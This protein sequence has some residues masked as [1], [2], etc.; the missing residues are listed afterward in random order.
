MCFYIE[1]RKYGVKIIIGDN[2]KKRGFTLVE[3]IAVIAVMGLLTVIIAPKIIDTFKQSNDDTMIIQEN[4]VKDSANLF[5]EDFCR[6]PI[7]SNHKDKCDEYEKT[8]SDGKAYFCLNSLQS[9]ISVVGFGTETYVDEVYYKTGIPCS[10]IVVFDKTG[11]SYTNGKVYLTCKNSGDTSYSYATENYSAYSNEISICGG[12]IGSA[13]PSNPVTPTN[14]TD[15]VDPV[16]PSN[17]GEPVV[18]EP[19]ELSTGFCKETGSNGKMKGDLNNDNKVDQTDLFVIIGT[20]IYQAKSEGRTVNYDSSQFSD[21]YVVDVSGDSNYNKRIM[22]DFN[23]DG[24]IDTL[25]VLSFINCLLSFIRNL[26]IVG[27][28]FSGVIDNIVTPILSQLAGV[29][30]PV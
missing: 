8:A 29:R 19:I 12:G 18:R 26:P 24:Y 1:K 10:G 20:I 15:P 28:I 23:Q 21:S 16:T 6:N 13:V 9:G 4:Q 27:P 14:P 2:M 7:S 11:R 3:L 22:L 30:I 5:I 17:P 25:D